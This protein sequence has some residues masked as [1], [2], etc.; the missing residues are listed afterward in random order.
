M[1]DFFGARETSGKAVLLSSAEQN[2]AKGMT[3]CNTCLGHFQLKAKR[4]RMPP[5]SSPF[6][7]LG[8]RTDALSRNK[9][10]AFAVPVKTET[11]HGLQGMRNPSNGYIYFK[12]YIK[13]S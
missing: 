4:E 10:F 3:V 1:A 11:W 5:F 7:K 12:V 6:R 9:A 2:W 13:K 8:L